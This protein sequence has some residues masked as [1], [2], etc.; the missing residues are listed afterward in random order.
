M[1]RIGAITI[2][3]ASV[4]DRD[5]L[6]VEL[7]VSGALLAEVGRADASIRVNIYPAVAGSSWEVLLA[8]LVAALELAR[9]ELESLRLSEI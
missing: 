7:W 4:R 6:V 3:V 8:D 5:E 9:K 1:T 2:E